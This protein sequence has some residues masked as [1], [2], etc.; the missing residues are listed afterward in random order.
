MVAQVHDPFGLWPINGDCQKR[1]PSSVTQHSGLCNM[2]T[3]IYSSAHFTQI[4]PPSEDS[5]N[6]QS[7]LTSNTQFLCIQFFLDTST[8]RA[9]LNIPGWAILLLLALKDFCS[10][11]TTSY[12]IFWFSNV[13]LSF[14]VSCLIH[15]FSGTEAT[16]G[17]EK[18][19]YVGLPPALINSDSYSGG[20]FKNQKQP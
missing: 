4:N 15:V 20:S 17:A 18:L 14:L 10:H 1:R 7:L 9:F 16:E 6:F 8:P 3:I 2:G 5:N 13:G 12:P 19:N 11:S